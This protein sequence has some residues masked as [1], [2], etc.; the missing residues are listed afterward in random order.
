MA[1]SSTT[2]AAGEKF[3]ANYL[4]QCCNAALMAFT[5]ALG[6]KSLADNIRVVGIN[7]GPSALTAMSRR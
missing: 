4:R 5:R 7:L 2:R 6:S 1:S 3:D